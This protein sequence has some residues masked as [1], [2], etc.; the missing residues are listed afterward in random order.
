MNNIPCNMAMHNF[1]GWKKEN[2]VC[3]QYLLISTLVQFDPHTIC[4][5]PPHSSCCFW[6]QRHLW[7]SPLH[8]ACL[9]HCPHRLLFLLLVQLQRCACSLFWAP[10]PAKRHSPTI[11]QPAWQTRNNSLLKPARQVSFNLLR[12]T[13]ENFNEPPKNATRDPVGSEPS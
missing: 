5:T 9:R 10:L 3:M 12:R 13:C 7:R 1:P 4:T 6:Q 2:K 11:L 8:P